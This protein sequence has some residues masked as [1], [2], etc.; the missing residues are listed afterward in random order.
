MLVKVK[1]T[2]HNFI[3]LHACIELM[4]LNCDFVNF[5]LDLGDK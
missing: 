2:E 1:T 4:T 5:D 3:S